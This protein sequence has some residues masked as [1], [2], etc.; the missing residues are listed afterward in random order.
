MTKKN[1]Y[2]YV[3]FSTP[4]QRKGRSLERQK[5]LAAEYAGSKGL[6]LDTLKTYHDLGVSGFKGK[7]RD[8]ALGAF[9]SAVE[10]GDI[11][12]GSFLLVESLDR[13]SRDEIL[14][15]LSQ[16]TEIINLGITV[17]T[18]QDGRVF[19][20]ESIKDLGNLIVSLTIMSRANEERPNPNDCGMR[21]TGRK[22][23]HGMETTS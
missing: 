10:K 23:W 7:N 22:N 15:A 16:L 18:L 6:E 5:E 13:L 11:E 19:D 20:R 17:V 21:G 4:E 12:S 2:S 3:R 8:A 1:A 9:L 14:I